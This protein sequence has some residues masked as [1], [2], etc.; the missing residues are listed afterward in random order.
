[1]KVALLTAKPNVCK[2]YKFNFKEKRPPNGIGFLYKILTNNNIDVDIYDRYAED[3]RW[4]SDNFKSYD[5]VGIY[6]CTLC[7]DDVFDVI[8]RLKCKRIAVG[9]P[10]AYIYPDTFPNKVNYIVRGEG[11]SIILDLVYGNIK[12]RIINT[13][14][15][16]NDELNNIPRFPYEYFWNKV[17]RK[18]YDWDLLFSPIKPIFTLNTSR[19]CPFS[20]SFCEV[21][22]IWG[23]T[24]TYMSV[25]RIMNDIKYVVSL[26]AKGV[27]FRED[28]FTVNNKRLENLCESIIKNN[29][30]IEWGCETRVDTVD[31]KLMKLMRD[32]GCRG[33]YIGVEHLSQRM[34][35]VFN[36]G[37]TVKQIMDFF[38]SANKYGIRTAASLIVEHPEETKED[39]IKREQRLKIIRP[40]KIWRN[41]FRK[42]F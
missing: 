39:I 40:T 19:G 28:N 20:C 2:G 8:N 32:A 27:W 35:N 11:E 10:H 38:K 22:R 13:D 21:K 34:L 29:V 4:P 23:R 42:L 31:D 7:M 16:T 25:D 33:F 5:L 41:K 36:K 24:I 37:T 30:R 26:G 12:D 1:M 15:L 3:L 18:Q 14:R 17:R 9:G 6:C